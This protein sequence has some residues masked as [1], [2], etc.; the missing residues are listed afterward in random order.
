MKK[1]FIIKTLSLFV[2]MTFESAIAS[3][4][5][6]NSSW[7]NEDNSYYVNY[8]V[9]TFKFNKFFDLIISKPLT[10]EVV[11]TCVIIFHGS[12]F[13]GK[14][15]QTCKDPENDFIGQFEI[16]EDDTLELCPDDGS[17][18]ELYY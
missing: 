1:I 5:T 12:Y 6:I 3:S 16:N 9:S 17:N 15:K 18:C 10:K 8:S 2:L 13:K 4:K 14:V 11:D 7:T